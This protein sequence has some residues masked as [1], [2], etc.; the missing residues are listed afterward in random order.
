MR[1][2]IFTLLL[3]LTLFAALNAPAHAS[4]KTSADIKQIDDALAALEPKIGHYP[5]SIDSDLER[6]QIEGK[7]R[8]LVRILNA[9]IK[10]NPHDME[11]LLRRGK[12]HVMGHNMDVPEAW[13]KAETDL[14]EVIRSQPENEEA[15]LALGSLYVNTHPKYAAMAEKL[16]L[17]AQL[18]HGTAPLED[19]HRGLMFAYYYQVKMDRALAEA[20]LLLKLSPANETYRTLRDIIATKANK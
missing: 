14:K 17:K 2:V 18:V 16:F 4:Q 10:K 11:L 6:K 12:L 1:S 20:E 13:K 9:S 8:S 15:L 3:V 7:Y 5:P 19:A